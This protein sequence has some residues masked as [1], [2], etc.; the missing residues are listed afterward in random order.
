MV[1]VSALSAAERG[2]AAAARLMVDW[3]DIFDVQQ[4]SYD[5][6]TCTYARTEMFVW[7]GPGRLRV[8]TGQEVHDVFGEA[9]ITTSRFVL[10][11]PPEADVVKLNHRVRAVSVALDETLCDREFRVA[12]VPSL[13]FPMYRPFGVEV[14]E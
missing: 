7:S 10:A 11:L 14:V 3:F 1:D 9:S 6:E 4:G 2:R 13:S 12:F 5:P 8:P